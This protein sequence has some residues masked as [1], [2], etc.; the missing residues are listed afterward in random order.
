MKKFI[1]FPLLF[2]TLLFAQVKLSELTRRDGLAYEQHAATPFTGK[3][4]QYYPDGAEQI[5]MEYKEGVSNG[6]LKSWYDKGNVQVEGFISNG[7][8]TGTWK[9]YYESGKLK[10]QST[11]ADNLE[12]GEEIC[13]FENGNIQKKGF[14][15]NGK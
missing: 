3:A 8:H 11:Y 15:V 6:E 1:L 13:W 9:L 5:M 14:Y 2:P 10:K 4:Y 12:N 7:Q